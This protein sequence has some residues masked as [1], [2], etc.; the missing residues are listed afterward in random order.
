MWCQEG[1]PAPERAQFEGGHVLRF[2]IFSFFVSYGA[3]A[4]VWPYPQIFSVFHRPY[5]LPPATGCQGPGFLRLSSVP[6]THSPSVERF[7]PGKCCT[8][9][10]SVQLRWDS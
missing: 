1:A 9:R 6:V 10:H 2:G 7:L 5:T 3:W 8:I 4:P